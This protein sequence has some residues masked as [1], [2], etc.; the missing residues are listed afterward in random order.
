MLASVLIGAKVVSAADSTRTV[1]AA[2]HDLGPGSVLT[3]ADVTSARVRLADGA[4]HYLATAA[5]VT[6]KTV[7]RAVAAGDLLPSS[8]LGATSPGTTVT[9]PLDAAAAPTIERGKRIEL[10]VT[11]K[12]CSAV[13]ILDDVTVQDVQAGGG[14]AFASGAT[15]SVVIRVPAPLAQRVVTALALD[16]ARIRAGIL[17]GVPAADANSRLTAL[18]G[19]TPKK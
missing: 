4:D 13:P 18:D 7:N 9:V 5:A 19:C 11:T 12:T 15:Q 3:P 17:D 16:G 2:A 1:W 14:S 6:G 10:W 8:A